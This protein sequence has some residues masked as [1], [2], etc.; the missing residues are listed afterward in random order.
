MA[1]PMKKYLVLYHMTAAAQRKAERM[2]KQGGKAAMEE[3]MKAWMAWAES[4]GDQ[5]VEMGAPLAKGSKIDA[6]GV[7]DSKRNVSGFSVVQAK[8]IG[9]ARKLL[10]KHPHL[11]WVDSGCSIEVHEMQPM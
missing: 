8:S 7:S 1:K 5:L 10:K 2:R 3:G 9:G 6:S 4:C 11:S